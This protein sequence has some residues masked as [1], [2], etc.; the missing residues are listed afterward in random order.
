MEILCNDRAYK[1]LLDS[2]SVFVS[3]DSPNLLWWDRTNLDNIHIAGL[4]G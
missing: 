2:P 3:S 1:S 4:A